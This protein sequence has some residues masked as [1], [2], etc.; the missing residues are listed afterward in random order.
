MVRLAAPAVGVHASRE[1]AS[2]ECPQLGGGQVLGQGGL[3]YLNR[4]AAAVKTPNRSASTAS[5]L[6]A[7][8]LDSALCAPLHVS[9]QN[10]SCSA[11]DTQ[12]N[13]KWVKC[14]LTRSVNPLRARIV[15]IRNSLSKF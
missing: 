6:G 8:L 13:N 2:A 7:R 11:G 10:H 14:P 4:P 5:S 1:G 12:E 9:V 15:A 3:D